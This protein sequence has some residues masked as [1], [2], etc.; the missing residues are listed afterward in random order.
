[1]GRVKSSSGA[2]E[3]EPWAVKFLTRRGFSETLRYFDNVLEMSGFDASAWAGESQLP[4]GLRAV[5]LAGLTAEVGLD[6]AIAA[7][8]AAFAEVREDVPRSSP[9]TPHTL[10][11][12]RTHL[13]NAP[14]Y[15]PEGTL[16]A[17]TDAGEVVALS[18]LRLNDADPARLDTGLTG[19]RRAWRRHGSG[20]GAEDRG[21]SAGKAARRPRDLDRQRHHQPSH[22]GAERTPGVPPAPRLHRDAL[23]RRMS[24]TVR[25]IGDGER[26]AAEWDAAAHLL[27]LAQPHE[28]WGA[29]E[30][31]K[32]QQEQTDWGYSSGV[33][34]ALQDGEVRG[35]AAYSQNPGAYHPQR[36][37]L[38]LAVHPGSG[39]TG[40]GSAL[41][42]AL[43]AILRGH[44]AQQARILA[45]EDH[46]GRAGFPGAARLHGRQ[47]LLHQFA[48]RDCLRRRAF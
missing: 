38:E 9:P 33:L 32:R 16:L 30:L 14:Q 13:L 8:Y 17:V 1:M 40:V 43:E 6:A 36:Y 2:Y 22:A 29:G 28:P 11:D 44:G 42:D 7:Y 19:T 5:S 46:R 25:P 34:V 3:E 18:E 41:W 47:A 15:F 37:V 39:G 31:R 26:D 27:S 20:A 24:V 35:M 21:A 12:F 23:G 45:R 10:E 48:G 4:A